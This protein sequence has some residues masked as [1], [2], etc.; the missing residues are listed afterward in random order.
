MLDDFG[1]GYSSLS[2]LKRHPIDV[3]KI[4]REFVD[5]L[6]VS[7]ENDAIV[8]AVLSMAKALG[9]DVIAEGVETPEQLHWLRVHGCDLAQGYLFAPPVPAAE[10]LDSVRGRGAGSPI[11]PG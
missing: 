4:D 6:G 7:D 11:S 2:H 9:L 5:G 10:L 8:S 1:T 3:L